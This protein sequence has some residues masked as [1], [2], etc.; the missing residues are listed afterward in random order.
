MKY[1]VARLFDLMIIAFLVSPWEIANDFSVVM[2]WI[3]IAVFWFGVFAMNDKMAETLTKDRTNARI[4]VRAIVCA[5]YISAIIYSDHLIMAILYT[6]G[7][8]LLFLR[9][10]VMRERKANELE[11]GK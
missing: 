4:A 7:S 1:F 9:A 11:V 10:Q 5:A 2:L 3:M 8:G 6:I